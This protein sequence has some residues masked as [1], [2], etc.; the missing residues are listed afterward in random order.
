MGSKSKQTRQEIQTTD[1]M[2]WCAAAH[3]V[4]IFC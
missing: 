4:A 2:I 1:M 3:T